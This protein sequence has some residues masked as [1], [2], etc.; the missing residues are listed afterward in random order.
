[1]PPTLHCL[2]PHASKRFAKVFVDL[3]G[4]Q[5]AAQKKD[6][7]TALKYFAKYENDIATLLK[8]LD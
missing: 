5:L 2:S 7:E 3:D 4:V 6:R 8:L 1:M